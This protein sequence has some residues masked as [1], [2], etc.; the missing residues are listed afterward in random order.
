MPWRKGTAKIGN[1]RSW[2]ILCL[3]SN[4][5]TFL[6]DVR[7]SGNLLLEGSEDR[8]ESCCKLEQYVVERYNDQKSEDS[9]KMRTELQKVLFCSSFCPYNDCLCFGLNCSDRS[10]GQ[11]W[12]TNLHTTASNWVSFVKTKPTKVTKTRW[13]VPI[14]TRKNKM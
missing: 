8:T 14:R 13:N 10:L 6:L 3:V 1:K 4:S 11:L 12:L 2:C 5:R 9:K 7:I